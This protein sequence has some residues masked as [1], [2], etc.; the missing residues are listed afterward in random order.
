MEVKEINTKVYIAEDGKKFLNENDCVEYE[1]ELAIFNK[2]K[3]F[4]I[5]HSI[6]FTETGNYTDATYV[7]VNTE[8]ISLDAET[9][10]NQYAIDKFGYVGPSVM[11]Y[12]FQKQY[13]IMG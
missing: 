7:A 9:I 4:M 11:G 6:D 12:G 13:S 3:Y 8:G 1:K 2:L 5:Y 10:A